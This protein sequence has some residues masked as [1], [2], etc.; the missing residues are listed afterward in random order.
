MCPRSALV[1]TQLL[2]ACSSLVSVTER[3]WCCRTKVTPENV[4]KLTT[5][6][7]SE[8]ALLR[9][10]TPLAELPLRLTP[11]HQRTAVQ[12]Q[13]VQQRQAQASLKA[14]AAAKAG[15]EAKAA[16]QAKAAEQ[17]A[18]AGRASAKMV[19]DARQRSSSRA[20]SGWRAGPSGSNCWT[21]SSANKHRQQS[22]ECCTAA[23]PPP[24]LL[25]AHA[26]GH[27]RSRLLYPQAFA[28]SLQVSITLDA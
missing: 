9:C 19:E 13:Q 1:P 4:L 25:Q 3:A 27:R 5:A 17:R 12:Q 14:A 2:Q 24:V 21:R 15:E 28:W 22:G 16:R 8:E 6:P 23:T 11:A 18:A 7:T 10:I 26:A 20:R